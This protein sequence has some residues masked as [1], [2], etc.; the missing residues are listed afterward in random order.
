M[1]KAPFGAYLI[2]CL[3]WMIIL[4]NCAFLLLFDVILKYFA[5]DTLD[6]TD[7][8]PY[9]TVVPLVPE[10]IGSALNSTETVAF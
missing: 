3:K 5:P 2:Y 10:V 1:K 9:A 6:T 7:D 4:S 8:S